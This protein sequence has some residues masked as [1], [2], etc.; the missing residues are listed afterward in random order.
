MP[1]RRETNSLTRGLY[2]MVQLAQRIH[3]QIDGVVPGGEARE[4]ADDFDL[5]Q[6]RQSG[7]R[8]ARAASPSS[9]CGVD[10]GHVERR[11][12]VAFLPGEDFSKIR[13]RSGSGATATLLT[14]CRETT[15]LLCCDPGSWL[16]LTVC[17]MRDQRGLAASD[18]QLQQRW[19]RDRSVRG[20]SARWR[21]TGWRCP[22]PDTSGSASKPPM[23]FCFEQSRVDLLGGLRRS[24]AQTRG[25]AARLRT[26]ALRPAA[27]TAV[28][29]HS[30]ALARLCNASSRMPSLP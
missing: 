6:L 11:Q 14:H 5:A 9:A 17:L 7:R 4:V 24:R 8:S 16:P 10:L 13:A 22:A 15:S 19:L 21:T 2:F 25:S 3:A 12:L 18:C 28:W 30:R 1:S 20:Y 27:L 26:A 29:P 23:I